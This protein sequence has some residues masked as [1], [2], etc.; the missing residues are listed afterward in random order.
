M[1]TSQK[2]VTISEGQR[3]F[4]QRLIA[5]CL[6]TLTLY[7]LYQTFSYWSIRWIRIGNEFLQL[8]VVAFSGA[9]SFSVVTTR[10][11]DLEKKKLKTILSVSYFSVKYYSDC[12][13]DYVSVF[14]KNPESL[15]EV[16]LWYK[17]NKHFLITSFEEL[18]PAMDFAASLSDKFQIDLLDST[19][20]GNPKWT[21]KP[22]P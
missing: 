6:Y 9:L 20:K 4:W 17:T 19:Q 5:A 15:Y 16:S 8:A 21:V 1:E 18:Q 14:R 13:L 2:E 22:S 11:F 3:P 12:E 7:A 10:C